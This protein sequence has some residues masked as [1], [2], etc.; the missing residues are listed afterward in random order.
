VAGVANRLAGMGRVRPGDRTTSAVTVEAD[1]A[2]VELGEQPTRR[3][4]HR[5]RRGDYRGVPLCRRLYPARGIPRLVAVTHG[6]R[7]VV[8]GVARRRSPRHG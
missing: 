8:A 7:M 5:R 1:I 3:V 2:V 4:A 6:L